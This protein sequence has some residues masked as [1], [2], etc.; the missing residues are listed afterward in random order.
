MKIFPLSFPRTELILI[1][2]S[3]RTAEGSR[4]DD[5][6]YFDLKVKKNFTKYEI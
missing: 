5:I 2:A 3:S 6:L 4:F 1:P